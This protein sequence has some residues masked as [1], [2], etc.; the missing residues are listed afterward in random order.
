MLRFLLLLFPPRFKACCKQQGWFRGSF[1]CPP[2]WIT[3]RKNEQH[4]YHGGCPPK[5]EHEGMRSWELVFPGRCFSSSRARLLFPWATLPLVTPGGWEGET[6]WRWW[7]DPVHGGG[8][9]I[10]Q[11]NH[12][13][14]RFFSSPERHLN[15]HALQA[16][17]CVCAVVEKE[18][19]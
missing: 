10:R 7:W 2:S 12:L 9:G 4:L 19:P 18:L 8:A 17:D 6:H 5:L 3:D 1:V 13:S 16:T 14:S 11:Q 15:V